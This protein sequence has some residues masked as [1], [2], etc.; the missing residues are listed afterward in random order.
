MHCINLESEY[1]VPT[2]SIQTESFTRAVKQVAYAR[3]MPEQRFVFVPQPVMGKSPTELRAY[4]DGNSPVT[5][6]PVMDDVIAALTRPLSREEQTAGRFDRSTPRWVEP[7]TEDNLHQLFLDN[8][9]TDRLPIILPRTSAWRQ[10][11]PGPAAGPTRWLDRCVRLR[12]AKRGH[13]PWRRWPST[14]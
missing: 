1:G 14:P 3:G 9:W 8:Q 10:C 11:W 5:G 13:T 12:R 6:Q 4:V 2:A 7:D